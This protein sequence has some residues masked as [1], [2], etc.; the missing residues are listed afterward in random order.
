MSRRQASPDAE[1]IR[2]CAEHIANV[3]AY[4]RSDDHTG[5]DDHPAWQACQR[6]EAAIAALP[7]STIA[8]VVAKARVAKAEAIEASA[9]GGELWDGGSAVGWARDVVND[10]L[11]VTGED[12]A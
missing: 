2:L 3:K 1:L 10:L 9:D 7:A 11:R 8:G 6:T 4:N 5:C 12:R